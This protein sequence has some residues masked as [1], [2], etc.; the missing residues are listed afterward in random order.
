M[1]KIELTLHFSI[2]S[3]ILVILPWNKFMCSTS[4]K[5][6]YVLQHK[7]HTG[8]PNYWYKHFSKTFLLALLKCRGLSLTLIVLIWFW[9]GHIHRISTELTLSFI[10]LA[11]YK[12]SLVITPSNNARNSATELCMFVKNL[13]KWK[14]C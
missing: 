12:H 1:S 6:E 10:L 11:I 3:P 2:V 4:D 9:C 14:I 13:V 8:E 5:R 7:Q